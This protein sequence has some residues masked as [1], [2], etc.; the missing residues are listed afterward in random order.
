MVSNRKKTKQQIL[1]LALLAFLMM[2]TTVFGQ[3]IPVEENYYRITTVPIPEGIRLEGGGVLALPTGKLMVCTRRGDVWLIENPTMAGNRNPNFKKF[4]SGLHEPLGIAQKNNSIY[5][6]QRGELTKLTDVNGDDIADNYETIYAWPLTSHYHEY[7]FGPIIDDNGDFFVTA[8]VSF[9]NAEWWRGI[10]EVPWRGWTM[11]ITEDG[12]MEPWAT[13]MRSP[14][15]YGMFEGELFYSDNQ[16]DWKGSGGIWHLPKGVFTGHPAGLAWT[17][18]SDSPV[19]L[20]EAQFYAKI[21]KRQEQINGSFIKPENIENEEDPDF[22]YEALEYFD[23]LQLPAVIL[24]HGLMGISNSEI[25]ED[26]TNGKFGPFSGQLLVGDQG[27]SKI[28]RVGL[29]KIKGQYQGFAIDFLSGF[30]S[31]VMRMDFD[32]QG[33]LFVGETNRGWGSAGTTNDGLEYVT[34][35]GK[36]PFEVKNVKAMP[37]GFEISFTQ[38][39]A[40]DEAK[41]LDAYYGKSYVYKYHAVYGSPQTNV[42]TF[43]PKGV[44]VSAD[45]L[46]LRLVYDGMRQYH[47]HEITLAGITNAKSSANLLH[48]TLYYTLNEIPE[49]EKLSM[50]SV[51]TKKKKVKKKVAVV[52]K[53][54]TKKKTVTKSAKKVTYAEVEPLLQKNTCIACHQ[55]GKKVV[56]PSYEDIAQRRYTNERIVELIYNPEPKNWPEYAT[57]MAPMPQVPRD[58]A[59]KIAAWINSLRDY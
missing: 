48:P 9:S 22:E 30:Q 32:N 14:A 21:D 51:S 34:W 27:Q 47:V 8:N 5:I 2:G 59:L 43:K 28:M 53:Q 12:E 25:L 24:P 52:K 49:G 10:S 20:T 1:A 16:G 13:G 26:T 35:T 11:K 42:E 18:H 37:D 33:N 3:G 44:K 19:K 50:S 54:S 40:V 29:E 17:S 6:A 36:V 41:F 46:S 56:G 23:E 38:P 57:P 31:G 4:A 55:T 45:G 39:I 7:S 58:E 15:G